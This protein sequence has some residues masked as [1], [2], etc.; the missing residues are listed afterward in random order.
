MSFELS[1]EPG[2]YLDAL[3]DTLQMVAVSGGF[4]LLAGIVTI[5]IP[6]KQHGHPFDDPG[7]IV[8][9]PGKARLR[10]WPSPSR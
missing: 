10:I 3:L 5:R 1:L 8:A 2:T 9:Q 4:A 6:F 7:R